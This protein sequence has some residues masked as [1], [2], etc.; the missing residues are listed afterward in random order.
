MT[1]SSLRRLLKYLPMILNLTRTPCLLHVIAQTI[2]LSK[3]FFK[4]LLHD[5]LRCHLFPY[6]PHILLARHVALNHLRQI[7]NGHFFCHGVSVT[8]ISTIP[9]PSAPDN[10]VAAGTS[11][12]RPL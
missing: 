7:L 6:C 10:T 2:Q 1:S 5:F 12:V 3:Y 11:T 9:K 4:P 8:L